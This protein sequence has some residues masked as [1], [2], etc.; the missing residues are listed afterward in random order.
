MKQ[1]E[2]SKKFI[3]S[4]KR[5]IYKKRKKERLFKEKVN[6]FRLIPDHP[7]LRNHALRNK[8]KK[9]FGFRAFSIDYD[10]RVIFREHN[11]KYY[12]VDIGNHKQVY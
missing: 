4:Y 1:I 5:R 8:N 10:L 9:W 3:Q 2:L 11:G 7:D 6:L 12:F